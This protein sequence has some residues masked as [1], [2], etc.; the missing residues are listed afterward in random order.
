MKILISMI[1]ASLAIVSTVSAAPVVTISW[2]GGITNMLNVT[3]GNIEPVPQCFPQV[4]LHDYYMG[5]ILDMY[6]NQANCQ[7]KRKVDFGI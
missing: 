3:T 6:V 5:N 7:A 2:P 1:I 4:W